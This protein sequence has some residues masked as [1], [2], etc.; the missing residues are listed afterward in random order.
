VIRVKSDAEERILTFSFMYVLITR[1]CWRDKLEIGSYGG[2][3]AVQGAGS[4]CAGTFHDMEEDHHGGG[5]VGMAEKVLDGAD[6]GTGFEQVCGKRMAKSVGRDA[7]CEGGLS[8][9]IADLAGHGVVVKVVTDYSAGARMRA[10]ATKG[11]TFLRAT[12]LHKRSVH[13]SEFAGMRTADLAGWTL[14]RGR[15]DPRGLS[16]CRDSR[17]LSFPRKSIRL[18][19]Q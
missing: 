12:G 5:D 14:A 10:G 2:L 4:P 6:V 18:E 3:E 11:Q 7:L 15:M 19:A 9:G 13:L 16:V 8:C 1:A 17:G